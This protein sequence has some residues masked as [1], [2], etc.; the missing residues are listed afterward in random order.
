MKNFNKLIGIIAYITA[1]LAVQTTL[2]TSA[3]AV[4]YSSTKVEALYG[5]DYLRGPDFSEV[6]EGVLTVVNATGFT[7]GDSFF[8]LDSANFDDIDG[9]GGTHLEWSVRYRVS[10][11]S[12]SIKGVYGIAQ[13][14]WDS[15]EFANKV[16]R[17]GG[18]SLDWDVPGFRFVKTNL[19]HRNDPDFEGNSVQFTLVWNKAFKI[20]AQ[21]FSFEGFAD[22]TSSE[23]EKSAA[24]FDYSESNLLTQ[25][26]IVW[27]PTK[28]FGLGIEY[29]YWKNRIG[30]D[31]V[32]EKAPQ[33]LAR[34]TF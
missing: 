27:H 29:Q 16:T 18:V 8:F 6:D 25:P 28:N 24:P 30:R 13:I 14:D 7:W 23:G 12:G 19:Q 9:T 4:T 5:Y 2:V 21:N 17:M 32:D 11:G 1:A 3:N 34:W 33:I 31:G 26:Q 20:G 22:W 10:K 15:G